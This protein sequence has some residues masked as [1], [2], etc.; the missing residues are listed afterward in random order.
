MVMISYLMWWCIPTIAMICM[1]TTWWWWCWWLHVVLILVNLILLMVLHLCSSSRS[2]RSINSGTRILPRVYGNVL[3]SSHL[4][5][6][7]T[8]LLLLLLL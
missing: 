2:S 4:I 6:K 1:R 3:C 8:L 7:A 5:W